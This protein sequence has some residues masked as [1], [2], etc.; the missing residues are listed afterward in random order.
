LSCRFLS[1]RRFSVL[2]DS[3]SIAMTDQPSDPTPAALPSPRWMPHI[4]VLIVPVVAVIIAYALWFLLI[5]VLSLPDWLVR[6]L[7]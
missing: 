4:W 2:L 1:R 5:A 7:R 3:L 6:V